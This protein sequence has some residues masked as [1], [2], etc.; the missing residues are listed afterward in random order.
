MICF[1]SHQP[2]EKRKK[3]KTVNRLYSCLLR[4]HFSY[5]SLAVYILVLGGVR[6]GNNK[7]SQEND[8]RPI[9]T[10]KGG[11]R[12]VAWRGDG[13]AIFFGDRIPCQVKAK[14]WN[15]FFL[16]RRHITEATVIAPIPFFSRNIMA[17]NTHITRLDHRI[18]SP[19]CSSMSD[20]NG[21]ST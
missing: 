4:Y 8:G 6:G 19:A 15:S 20:S 1:R 16:L 9:K 13:S 7:N 14:L 11:E 2:G 12:E 3:E 5:I 17:F 10:K 21:S 18:I